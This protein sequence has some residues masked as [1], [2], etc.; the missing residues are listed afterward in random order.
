MLIVVVF[1]V[2][3]LAAANAL[4]SVLPRPGALRAAGAGFVTRL[5]RQPARTGWK[6]GRCPSRSGRGPGS[7]PSSS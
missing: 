2:A 6:S 3:T 5:V 7:W 1:V 4:A